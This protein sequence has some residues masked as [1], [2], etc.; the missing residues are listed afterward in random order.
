MIA[1]PIPIVTF[2]SLPCQAFDLS[3]PQVDGFLVAGV[4]SVATV[5]LH[6]EICQAARV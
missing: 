4:A 2:S 6:W 1:L 5:M 3:R